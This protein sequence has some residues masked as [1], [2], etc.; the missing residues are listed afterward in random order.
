[1]AQLS[2]RAAEQIKALLKHL[3]QNFWVRR[4][5]GRDPLAVEGLK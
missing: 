3:D 1:V 4:D 2:R 5:L